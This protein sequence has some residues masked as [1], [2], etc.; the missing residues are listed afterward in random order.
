MRDHADQCLR[1]PMTDNVRALN[2]SNC[3]ALV[4]YEALRQQ[5]FAGLETSHTYEHDKLK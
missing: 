2:L 1:I 3:A 5:H 4:I